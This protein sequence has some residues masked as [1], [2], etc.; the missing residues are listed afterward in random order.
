M[1]SGKA[2]NTIFR[3]LQQRHVQQKIQLEEQFRTEK[4]ATQDEARA[5]VA[6][7]RQNEKDMLIAEQEKVGLYQVFI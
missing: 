4:M 6:E 2:E 3:V 5:Y 1:E 7:I